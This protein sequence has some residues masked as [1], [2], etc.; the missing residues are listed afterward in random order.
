LAIYEYLVVVGV[1]VIVIAV[2]IVVG[3]GGTGRFEDGIGYLLK[4][5]LLLQVPPLP[6]QYE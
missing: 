2:Q 3:T 6:I 5:S 4:K 1:G